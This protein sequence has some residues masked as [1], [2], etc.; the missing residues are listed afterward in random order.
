MGQ[1]FSL[2]TLSAGSAGIDTPELAD[3]TYERSLGS[4]RFM[5]SIRARHRDGMGFVK[6]VAK[7]YPTMKLDAYVRE[8]LRERAALSQVPNALSYE[9]VLETSTNGYLVRQYFY[10]SLYDRMSTRPFL[11]DIEK[12]WLAFQLLS[13]VRDCHTRQV[14]HGDIKTEN[15]LVTSWNWLFLTDFSASFKPTFLPEDNPA[16]FSYYFDT[17]GRRTCYLAPERFLGAGELGGR[18]GKV[19]G[20]MDIFSVGCVIA[21]LFVE[22]PI[23]SLSQLYKY[24]MGEYDPE[25]AHL[26]RIEDKEIRDLVAHMIQPQPESRYSADEYLNFWRRKAF[27]EYFY[28][29]LHQYLGLI[30][31]PSAGR[32]PSAIEESLP[33]EADDRIDRVYLDFDKISF[34][35]GYEHP[36]SLID[37]SSADIISGNGILPVHVDIPRNQHEISSV[38]SRPSNDG[39][40]IFLALVVSSLRNT[41]RASARIRACDIL[42]AF[43]ERLTD[44]AKLDRILPY[45]V[46]LLN[47]SDDLV[48]IAALRTL[49]QLMALVRVLSPVNAYVFPEYLLPKLQPFVPSASSGPKPAVRAMY[50]SCLASLAM[51]ASRFLDM[52]H[53]LRADGSLPTADP[54]S[55]DGASG[56]SAYQTLYDVARKD[57]V[58]H[59][60]AHTKALLTDNESS[61][62]RAFLGSISSLCVFFGTPKANDVI[63]SHLNTYLNDKDWMLRCAFFETIVGVAT[64][65]GGTSLEEFI[66]PLMVQ[67][68]TDPE[69]L[70]LE[71]VIRSFVSMAEL[72]LFQ[73]SKIW[74]LVDVVSRFIVHPNIWIRGAGASFLA[75]ATSH[76]S[77]ADNYCIIAPLMLPYL[78]SLE[79]EFREPKILDDLRKPLT[80][81]VFDMASSWV[82][83]VDRGIFWKPAQHQRTFSLGSGVDP[84][85]MPDAKEFGD[86][87]LARVPKNDEDEQ[88]VT[89]LRNIG[90]GP[91]DEWKL[92]AL[93]EYIWRMAP[94]KPK[95]GAGNSASHLNNVINLKH[96]SITPQ[97][98]FFN[99]K[100]EE[101]SGQAK[102]SPRTDDAETGPHTIA[103]AL[104][105]ASMT[106]DDSLTRKKRANMAKQRQPIPLRTASLPVD[107]N[108]S[109]A[110][111]LP[112]NSP[113]PSSSLSRPQQ[114]RR[115]SPVSPL[116]EGLRNGKLPGRTA[117]I[118]GTET[119]NSDV[120]S[121]SDS[122]S[123]THTHQMR[124]KSSAVSL[125]NR[126]D[127]SKALPETGTTS[128]NASGKVG[129][130]FSKETLVQS[131]LRN[132]Q[133]AGTISPSIR[134]RAAYSYEGNDPSVLK[135]LDTLYEDNFPIDAL[136]FGPAVAPITRRQRI[137]KS[138]GQTSD[139]PW[140]PDGNLVAMYSEHTGAIN[141]VVVAPDHAFFLTGSDDG[142]VKVWDSSRLE[143][144]VAHRSRQTHRHAAGAPVKSLCF[145]EN[146]HCFVS[147][148]SDGSLQVVKVDCRTSS[149]SSS[150]S[151]SATRY[152]K[153]RVLRDHR[154]RNDGE[155]ALWLEHFKSDTHSLLLVATNKCRLVAIDLRTMQELY[156]FQNPLHYGTPT[157]FCLD[158]KR[159]WVLL[160]T[161]HGVLTLW[162]LRFRVRLKSW[163]LPGA[164]AIHRLSIHPLKGRGKWI[165]VAGGS[166]AHGEVSVW[167]LDKVQC[168]EIYRAGITRQQESA[169]SGPSSS[170][171]SKTYEAWR[172]DD[173]RPEGMLGR[174]AT[175]LLE[176]NGS[177]GLDRAGGGGGGG[178]AAG[179]GISGGS[180]SF[181]R[182]FIA[183]VDAS[184]GDDNNNNNNNNASSVSTGS[185]GSSRS[186]FLITAGADRKVRFWDLSGSGSGSG[187][188]S[189]SI[190]SGRG[191]NGSG[192]DASSMVI[193]GLGLDEARPTFVISHPTPTLTINTERVPQQ[194]GPT[195]PNAGTGQAAGLGAGAGARGKSSSSSPNSGARRGLVSAGAGGKTTAGAGGAG[196]SGGGGGSGGTGG[197]GGVGGPRPPR[198][199]VI[200]LQQQQLL[201][202]HLDSI[203]DVALL[204]LPYGM[205]VSVDRSGVIYV[206]Q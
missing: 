174:F 35:L 115:P 61:V 118:N 176:S 40:L 119:T 78:K 72:G 89:R 13:A 5:K 143:R 142:T 19:N 43:A 74:E 144:N 179:V 129:G 23:F 66:L 85:P 127:S 173:E 134:F 76:L 98:I 154:L 6:V 53:A 151:S 158:R 202:S 191:G 168:R 120:D 137:K 94:L 162:D 122:I 77:P 102:S 196:G 111:S 32:S 148:A 184:D 150:S 140:R 7:P 132:V 60:E 101:Y 125:L 28:S 186:G 58:E 178:A 189:S 169:A 55:E 8:I 31:D 46:T 15:I 109:N 182:T 3:L 75:A 194:L 100:V 160:A 131:P 112:S 68:L 34:F 199:T 201:R 2:T 83:K 181:F 51:T 38:S 180:S 136:E 39:T 198:S 73:R 29:F 44:E 99:D 79:A 36:T 18:K 161:S 159:T 96:L 52:T 206:F 54:E 27:P 56:H 95:E 141:R 88:W 123:T 203:L 183:G 197:S 108:A 107:A 103:D 9:R 1:G 149:G 92:L 187:S 128:A 105:D 97:T 12:K 81:A 153:L 167:D 91:E 121:I 145:V 175:T 188:G 37:R 130:P 165:C 139:A 4:A 65:V 33:G 69:E 204:E 126:K 195:S 113:S 20:A 205:V 82:T 170:A 70:V 185:G 67:A 155:Y 133:E 104:L 138:S 11:E 24:R 93:R 106:I 64:F 114:D 124:H 156:N 117:L 157:C 135:L 59:F 47:D 172:V 71:K 45:I 116:D 48:K 21:E 163:G 152:G 193:S 14:F 26:S 41:S 87:A 164:S 147:G 25:H 16:D 192:T 49:T 63:L 80:R 200:S 90:M 17:S 62:R 177:A 10:G 110:L 166:A 50:A 22:S 171:G 190:S 86:N 84:I 57:L 30:T 146:T 42:L